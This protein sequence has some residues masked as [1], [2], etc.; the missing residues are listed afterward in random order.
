MASPPLLPGA[1]IW[2]DLLSSDPEQA[3]RFY[4]RLFGWTATQAGPEFGGYVNFFRHHRLVAGLAANTGDAPDAWMVYLATTD[5]D[6]T[7][8]SVLANGGQVFVHD[9]VADFGSVVMSVD[10]TGATVGAWQP[11]THTG[12]QLS[13][14]AG[15]PVW[16]ELHTPHFADAVSF[17][18]QAFDWKPEPFGDTEGFRMVTL[19]LGTHRV[20]GILE[21]P[22]PHTNDRSQWVVYFAVADADESAFLITQ[23]GGHLTQSVTG[24]PFGRI[25]QA[26]DPTGA[27][28]TLIEL[29]P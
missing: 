21:T 15:T 16:F 5:A 25:A 10:I 24:S 17:Y 23:L 27:S 6:D 8:A 7:A 22:W 3:L 2:I 20:A 14:E 26:I 28:F 11:G 1:P 4:T 13:G 9:K 18:E 12:I 29:T 19:G